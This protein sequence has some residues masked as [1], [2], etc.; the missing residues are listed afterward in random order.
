ML[1]RVMISMY[2]VWQMGFAHSKNSRKSHNSHNEFEKGHRS[3]D[4]HFR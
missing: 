3:T 2:S 4:G 1:N